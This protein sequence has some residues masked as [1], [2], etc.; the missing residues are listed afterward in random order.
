[1]QVPTLDFSHF[2][3]GNEAQKLAVSIALVESFSNHGFVKVINHGVSET[4]I[5]EL[6]TLVSFLECC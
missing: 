1:M 6:A 4:S 5:G 2:S 3:N